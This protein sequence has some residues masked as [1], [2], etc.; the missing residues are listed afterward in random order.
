MK[1]LDVP[2][3]AKLR[4]TSIIEI[5]DEIKGRILSAISFGFAGT[6]LVIPLWVG[7]RMII[8]KG[9]LVEAA[10]KIAKI[11]GPEKSKR[12]QDRK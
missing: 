10:F 12:A 3:K 5:E 2:Q 8:E 4:P 6:K 9:K 7:K 11:V 1:K